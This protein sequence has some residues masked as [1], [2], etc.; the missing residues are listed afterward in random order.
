MDQFK[1]TRL[2]STF[3]TT[4]KINKIQANDQSF[5]IEMFQLVYLFKAT[6]TV[7]IYKMK[8][9][10]NFLMYKFVYKSLLQG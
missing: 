9:I 8:F 3:F 7:Y 5:F 6:C 10:Y 1:Y 4:F 2:N